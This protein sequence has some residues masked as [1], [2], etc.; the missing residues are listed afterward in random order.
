MLF[1]RLRPGGD[2]GRRSVNMLRHGS[3]SGNPTSHYGWALIFKKK[4]TLET[5]RCPFQVEELKQNSHAD[6]YASEQT[7][8]E[9]ETNGDEEGERMAFRG[10]GG[11]LGEFYICSVDTFG[12][13]FLHI[14][15]TVQKGAGG[16]RANV[17]KGMRH[18]STRIGLL[19][20]MLATVVLR[21]VS[22]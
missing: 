9:H 17:G 3:R 1:T 16:L 20:I 22:H 10:H 7:V 5:I 8:T 2:Q 15:N 13:E 11:A 18:R 21:G 19:A 6:L 12:R 14:L 4:L